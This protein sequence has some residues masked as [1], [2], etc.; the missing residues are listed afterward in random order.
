MG[1]LDFIL[2]KKETFYV[3]SREIIIHLKTKEK[4][5]FLDLKEKII[6]FC[7]T[8][9]FS[10]NFPKLTFLIEDKVRDHANAWVS[11]YEIIKG[12]NI[13]HFNG[14]F[15]LYDQKMTGKLFPEDTLLKA[16]EHEIIHLWHDFKSKQI[17]KQ[18]GNLAKLSAQ[19]N[20]AQIFKIVYP[21][22]LLN[23]HQENFRL[24]LANFIINLY[25]EG[26]AEYISYLER[27]SLNF[28][29][30][31]FNDTYYIELRNIKYVLRVID[32]AFNKKYKTDS[33]SST[34]LFKNISKVLKAKAYSIGSNMVYSILYIDHDMNIDK[35]AILDIFKFI[36]KYES[37]MKKVNLKPLVSL[38][39]GEGII[40]YKILVNQIWI[41]NKEDKSDN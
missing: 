28:S 21:K 27:E 8:N 40:D 22:S 37:C 17:Q 39:S 23:K 13:M 9:S 14:K 24:L 11:D 18:S 32:Q 20:V 7:K 31:L 29:Q 25:I 30:R 33:T 38:T 26:L 34:D 6:D 12:R 35:I 4:I 36:R 16:M 15:V 41:M 2:G 10:K 5:D 3:D 1:F 19:I